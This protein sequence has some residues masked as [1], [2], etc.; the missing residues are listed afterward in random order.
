[1]DG[2]Q[3]RVKCG[4]RWQD[5]NPAL[6]LAESPGFVG[7]NY[8]FGCESYPQIPIQIRFVCTMYHDIPTN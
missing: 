1:M 6:G 3:V 8:L 4:P 2:Q 7:P 5:I